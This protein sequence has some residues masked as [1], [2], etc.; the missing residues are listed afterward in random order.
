MPGPGAAAAKQ[1]SAPPAK[2]AGPRPGSA[3]PRPG[4]AGPRPGSAVAR[5]KSASPER[6]GGAPRSYVGNLGAAAAH[7][8]QQGFPSEVAQVCRKLRVAAGKD[9]PK[10]LFAEGPGPM[11]VETF[12]M[13]LTKMLAKL[14][15]P[16]SSE[17]ELQAVY[18]AAL[19]SRDGLFE[20]TPEILVDFMNKEAMAATGGKGGRMPAARPKSP[21]P[22]ALKGGMSQKLAMGKGGKAAGKAAQ[23]AAA[24]HQAAVQ[25][26]KTMMAKMQQLEATMSTMSEENSRLRTQVDSL[27]SEADMH[28]QNVDKLKCKM[29]LLTNPG[30][31]M[32][33]FS[34]S[35]GRA[36]FAG[37][38]TYGSRSGRSMSPQRYPGN[39][40]PLM[41]PGAS[42]L[43]ASS[44]LQTS[45]SSSSF[46]PRRG[47]FD[48]PPKKYAG[49]YHARIASESTLRFAMETSNVKN[50][51]AALRDA[52]VG[53]PEELATVEI[54]N[55]VLNE[56]SR[57]ALIRDATSAQEK[58]RCKLEQV[59]SHDR[60]GLPAGAQWSK[61]SHR[62]EAFRTALKNATRAIRLS[63]EA[64]IGCDKVRKPFLE[65][66]RMLHQE[67]DVILEQAL[68]SGDGKLL[69]SAIAEAR[70]NGYD[71]A[72]D[73]L[74]ECR[75]AL[76]NCMSED[77]EADRSGTDPVDRCL[78]AIKR[79]MD[80][81]KCRMNSFFGA[82]SSLG[83]QELRA[84]VAN[85]GVPMRDS[86]LALLLERVDL[87][88]SGTIEVKELTRAL[89]AVEKRL[90]SRK[91]VTL[92]APPSPCELAGSCGHGQ[93]AAPAAPGALVSGGHDG[94]EDVGGASRGSS[95]T[96]SPRQSKCA[97]MEATGNGLEV[98]TASQGHR[99]SVTD[100]AAKMGVA[101]ARE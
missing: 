19:D 41:S 11:A 70:A 86:D 76:E 89:Q 88:G 82:S 47:H 20:V 95:R 9:W 25:D 23:A 14:K 96:P 85:L 12:Q 8:G 73:T 99:R 68:R 39:R 81:E 40:S 16:A 71:E 54:V 63:E 101:M 74:L 7:G 36:H 79:K 60:S 90:A 87:D 44:P 18:H 22:A 92:P 52:F 48:E 51:E 61:R 34:P 49:A 42:S 65:L 5:P 64:G 94:S 91:V 17:D 30:P 75:M 6:P 72:D 83:F 31:S 24:Q 3:G 27:Q 50:L 98:P 58:A 13:L 4:S 32:S 43:F 93:L 45:A 38:S 67:T 69:R 28:K 77:E 1:P 21:S 80:A 78:L 97:S 15:F 10:V 57:R 46:T 59:M 33:G 53:T 62:T 55:K 2:A 56:R 26:M 29:K 35:P 100:A 84:L 37:S 66:T